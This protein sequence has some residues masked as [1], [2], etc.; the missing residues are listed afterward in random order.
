MPEFPDEIWAIFVIWGS[1]NYVLASNEFHQLK[2]FYGENPQ[3]P[4]L[5]MEVKKWQQQV[6]GKL[7]KD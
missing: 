3:S 6:C 5:K 1:K 2:F 4:F 7:I